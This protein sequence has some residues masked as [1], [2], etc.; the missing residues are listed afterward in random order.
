MLQ[1]IDDE[2]H[3]QQ[4]LQRQQ[5]QLEA[6]VAE[7]TASL[8]VALTEAEH[9]RAA[10][11]SADRAKG[12][13]LA[14]MS[15][16]LRTPLN[17]L[18]GLTELALA[19]A[20]SPAQRRQLEVALQSGR[21]LLGLISEVLEVARLEGTPPALADQPFDLGALLADAMRATVPL[22]RE[23]AVSTLYDVEGGPTAL[24]GDP[25]RLRQIIV[26]LLGNAAKFTEQG[27][28]EVLARLAPAGA[29]ERELVL[30]V[31]DTGP[32]MAPEV[33]ARVFEPF[34]QGESASVR[35]GEGTGLGLAIAHGL[36]R[37]MDGEL[38][39]DSTPGIGSTFTLRVVLALQPGATEEP[40]PPPGSA[41]IA[42]AHPA[43]S[44]WVDG[45][46]RRLGW[47]AR[48]VIGVEA[49]HALARAAAA[50]SEPAPDLVLL[51]PR[52]TPLRPGD[53][54]R[55]RQ[56][57]PRT[58]IHLLLRADWADPAI[59]GEAQRVGAG[60][61]VVPTT[62]RALRAL[63]HDA[64]RARAAGLPGHQGAAA[65]AAVEADAHDHA[66][67]LLVEDNAVNRLIGEQLLQ[68]LGLRVR[69]VEDGA[70]SLDAC[71][72]RS[73]D[74]VLMDVRMPVM[75]G[76]EATRRLRALQREGRLAPFAVL[77]LSAHALEADRQAALQ[78]GMDDYLT[79]PIDAE[80][81]RAAVQHWV[82]VGGAAAPRP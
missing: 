60:T 57:L 1:D 19:Q 33:A 55:L 17:G 66:E 53:L 6:L 59:E 45:R 63:L 76:L 14:H 64:A 5:Q 46:L 12:R 32:G 42:A 13:F 36:A 69:S 20:E 22:L 67:V 37:A 65:I 41:W 82:R 48:S 73:P 75:D 29:G 79:K 78:A 16:E 34:Y 51:S 44:A 35:R 54:T 21:S 40:L 24:R 27:R 39:V 38:T 62:P 72:Q 11:E 80:R 47:Q 28:I 2:R 4:A 52:A 31:A 77:G 8:H 70:Q 71:L 49:L 81:L 74:L 43:E 7:R 15:H 68:H 58:T 61:G 50:G 3:A 10:A 30:S 23:R 26:N 18:L 56:D 9:A 25:A